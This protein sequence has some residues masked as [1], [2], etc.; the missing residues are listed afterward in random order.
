MFKTLAKMKNREKGF[1]LIELLIV[2]AIIGILAAIAI[3]GYLGMQERS[4]KGAVTR[5]ASAAEPELQAWLNSALKGVGGTQQDLREVDSNGNG[6]IDDNDA[7]NSQLGV[8][9]TG[10]N[11][12][13]AYVSARWALFSERSP[14]DPATSLWKEGDPNSGQIA[15]SATTTAPY[16]IDIIAQDSKGGILHQKSIYSD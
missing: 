4:R 5:A 8:W 1:T 16:R 3:P 10:G 11:L 13:S 2:V 15:V 12:A 14:W 9:L 6:Q 7:T